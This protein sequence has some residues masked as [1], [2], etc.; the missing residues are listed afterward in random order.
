MRKRK[1]RHNLQVIAEK[2]NGIVTPSNMLDLAA[3]AV[4]TKN[5][6]KIDTTRG[7]L[8]VAT[9]MAVD[10]VDGSI[11]RATGTE[12]QIGAKIDAGAD[13]LN[14]GHAL[15]YAW[16]KNLA[17]K[18][19]LALVAIQNGVNCA[20]VIHDSLTHKSTRLQTSKYGKAATF[21]NGFGVGLNVIGNSIKDSHPEKAERL[22]SIGTLLGYTG[23]TTVGVL[24]N[25][26]YW[27]KT[28]GRNRSSKAS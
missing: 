21:T 3:T 2:S 14:A 17:P 7:V 1:L 13:K 22:K 8:M 28:L 10:L 19:L 5:M 9:T 4:A 11:A 12:S 6:S 16:K 27:K 18:P 15:Y 24:A 20:A 26:D 23:L 25:L